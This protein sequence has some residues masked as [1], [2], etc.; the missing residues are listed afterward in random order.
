MKKVTTVGVSVV[1]LMMATSGAYAQDQW[2]GCHV[3]IQGGALAVNDS[4]T[5]DKI[6]NVDGLGASGGSI[7]GNVGCDALLSQMFLVGVMADWNKFINTDTSIGINGLGNLASMSYDNQW[8]VGGRAGFLLSP[9]VLAYGLVAYTGMQTSDLRVLNSSFNIP[10][11]RGYAVGGGLETAL[12]KSLHLG[13][14][15]RYNKYGEETTTIAGNTLDYEP[16]VQTVRASLTWNFN[17]GGGQ[18]TYSPPLK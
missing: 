16:T 6:I 5:F 4:V 18:E 13:V 15:Y 8:S 7:G 1:A 9:N 3:G 17:F 11:F 2:S 14:E 10:D 12:T